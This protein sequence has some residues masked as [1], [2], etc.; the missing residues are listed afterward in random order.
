[1]AAQVSTVGLLLLLG[2]WAWFGTNTGGLHTTS[3]RTAATNAFSQMVQSMF[4]GQHGKQN[5]IGI[6]V[7]ESWK[8]WWPGSS[9]CPGAAVKLAFSANGTVDLTTL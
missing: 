6:V 7:C 9:V 4:S 8:C 3:N 5:F 1:M 2:R